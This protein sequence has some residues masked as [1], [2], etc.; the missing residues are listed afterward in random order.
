[1]LRRESTSGLSIV[2]ILAIVIGATVTGLVTAHSGDADSI[3]ACVNKNGQVRIIDPAEDCTTLPG[4][5]CS[6]RN[7]LLRAVLSDLIQWNASVRIS[8]T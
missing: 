3:H 5:S 2:I 1:M 6:Q 7:A 8:C 4:Q